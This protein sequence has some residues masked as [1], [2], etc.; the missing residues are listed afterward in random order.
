MVGCTL[1]V[2]PVGGW[3][4]MDGYSTLVVGCNASTDVRRLTCVDGQWAGVTANCTSATTN[5][6]NLLSLV[7]QVLCRSGHQL[8]YHTSH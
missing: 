3:M 7:S 5:T 1:P 4:K 8:A 2:V 6:G